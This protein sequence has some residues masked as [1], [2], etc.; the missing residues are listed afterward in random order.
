MVVVT[1]AAEADATVTTLLVTGRER[2]E[3]DRRT[4]A[5]IPNGAGDLFAGLLLGHL[6]NGRADG[7]ALDASLADLDRVLAASTGRDVLQLSALN[8]MTPDGPTGTRES[9]RARWPSSSTRRPAA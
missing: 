7:A 6:L 5:G 4:H 2:I 8:P 3:R 1:S 9:S